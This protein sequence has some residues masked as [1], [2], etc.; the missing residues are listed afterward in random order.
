M[1]KLERQCVQIAEREAA[2]FGASI[3]WAH[4]GKH[5]CLTVMKGEKLRK[6]ALSCTPRSDNQV[7]WVAQN[8]RRLVREINF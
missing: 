5:S 8:V 4:E 7:H 6:I 3:M 2:K 1:T